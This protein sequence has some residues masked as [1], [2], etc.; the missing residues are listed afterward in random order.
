MTTTA[1]P[2]TVA[3]AST[4][5]V[6]IGHFSI[7]LGLTGLG[8]AWAAAS[9]H[10]G[11]S[12]L[13]A[14]L[15]FG[16]AALVWA[17]FTVAYVVRIATAADNSFGAELRHPLAGPL[18]AYIPVIAILLIAHYRPQLGA[19]TT[20][21]I[22][23]AVG[24]LAINIAQLVAHWLT[25]PLDHSAL[26]PGYFLPITAGP[27]I[28]AIGLA[29]VGARE[30]AI[31][32]FGLGVCFGLVIGAVIVGRLMLGGP[33]PGPFV[34]VLSVLLSPPLTAGVAWFAIQG[35]RIDAVQEVIAGI[36]VMMLLVQLVLL[37]DY[38]R[39]PFTTQHWAFTFPL[40]VMG[41]ASI[42]WAGGLR[43]DGWQVAAWTVLAISTALILAIL[44]ATLRG[45]ARQ[46]Q[47]RA[48]HRR[49]PERNDP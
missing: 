1:R 12:E 22:A 32:V 47:T 6:P 42:R 49:A 3:A 37:P 5:T 4:W 11:A 46:L 9:Q 34:P 20:W 24:A 13:P 23:L 33:L 35:G 28:A 27:F 41:N 45:V 25:A 48:A 17:A 40:A 21:L 36:T 44:A 19:A 29:A 7:P 18:T 26:H 14:N 10:L 2:A 38:L 8:G 15:A 16:T 30:A 31:A 39:L 43:F